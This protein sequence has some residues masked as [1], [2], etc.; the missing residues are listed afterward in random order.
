MRDGSRAGEFEFRKE[1]F[2]KKSMFKNN[3]DER[4]AT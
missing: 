1:M 4:F 2:R 3:G